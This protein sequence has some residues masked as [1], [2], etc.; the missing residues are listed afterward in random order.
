VIFDDSVHRQGTLSKQLRGM[1]Q[2][3]MKPL[4]NWELSD[5]VLQ[6]TACTTSTEAGMGCE[7]DAA[8]LFSLTSTQVSF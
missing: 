3:P 8:S 7:D 1:A 2:L 4:I 6:Q 5:G